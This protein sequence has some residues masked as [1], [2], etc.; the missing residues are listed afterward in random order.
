VQIKMKYVNSLY[1]CMEVL[2][3]FQCFVLFTY[4]LILLLHEGSWLCS[5][6]RKCR[7]FYY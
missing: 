1:K 6:V 3:L 5:L 4:I 2:F 7:G